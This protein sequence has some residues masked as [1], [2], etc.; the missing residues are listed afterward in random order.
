MDSSEERRVISRFNAS[1]IVAVPGLVLLGVGFLLLHTAPVP[2]QIIGQ[3]RVIQRFCG[4]V[5]TTTGTAAL[6]ASVLLVTSTMV[7][8]RGKQSR[9]AVYMLGLAVLAALVALT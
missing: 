4:L 3:E 2:G 5:A 6:A 9:L 1:L 7:R 8:S